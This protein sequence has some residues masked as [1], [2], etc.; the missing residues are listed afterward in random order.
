MLRPA[1]SSGDWVTPIVLHWERSA[2]ASCTATDSEK[3]SG[4]IITREMFQVL[5]KKLTLGYSYIIETTM[6]ARQP[7]LDLEQLGQR[8]ILRGPTIMLRG[9][10][11]APGTSVPT[12]PGHWFPSLEQVAGGEKAAPSQEGHVPPA[13]NNGP[14][15]FSTVP[16]GE[17]PVPTPK[18]TTFSA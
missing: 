3:G 18:P 1:R 12:S 16:S 14:F 6:E 10:V 4:E 15:L 5:L 17:T 8:F 13:K 2:L 11:P 7:S 9:P